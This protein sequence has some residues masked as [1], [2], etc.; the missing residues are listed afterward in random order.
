[1]SHGQLRKVRERL[2]SAEEGYVQRPGRME[3]QVRLVDG[4]EARWETL[5]LMKQDT[6]KHCR[7]SAGSDI[8]KIV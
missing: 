7:P 4:L 5:D 1:M 8:L 2:V 3:E 6:G